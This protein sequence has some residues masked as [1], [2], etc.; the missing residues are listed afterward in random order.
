MKYILTLVL[1]VIVQTSFAQKYDATADPFE[2]IKAA[3]AIAQKENKHI[4]VMVGGDWCI[5]C[6]AFDKL[7]TTDT[8]IQS[9]LNDNYEVVHINYSPKNYNEAFLTAYNNPGRFGFP[10]ILILDA[11]GNLIHTQNSEYLE[12]PTIKGHNPKKVNA[13][14]TDWS[15][16]ALKYHPRKK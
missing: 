15:P 6:R 9:T 5:W 3:S 11:K 16:E 8:A 4:F 12:D 7:A 2:Q 14:L 1:F 13:F 10:V